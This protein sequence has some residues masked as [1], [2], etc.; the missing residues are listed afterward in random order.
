MTQISNHI[1]KNYLEFLRELDNNNNR[2]WFN[3]NK[4]R[5]TK[6]KADFE[7]WL[8]NSVLDTIKNYDHTLMHITAKDCTYRINRDIR[9]SNDKKPYKTYLPAFI[10]R[11]GKCD[12]ATGYYIQL[13][14]DYQLLI[15]VGRYE[16]ESNE[17]FRIRKKLTEID[18]D[19]PEFGN[20]L[21]IEQ[22][23]NITNKL[24][25]NGFEDKSDMLKTYPRGFDKNHS[26]IDILRHKNFVFAQN[27]DCSD[28][29]MDT[30]ATRI[31]N[32]IKDSVQFVH[33]LYQL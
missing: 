33:W 18:Q 25:N 26:E 12:S 19:N 9:F 11:Q 7:Q 24:I 21:N 5:Y 2:T 28:L 20:N 31:N 6:L 1:I 14:T 23:H 27:I 32:G 16:I 22:F 3:D 15:G 10:S 17:L 4:S 30:I 8:D 29:N 13:T